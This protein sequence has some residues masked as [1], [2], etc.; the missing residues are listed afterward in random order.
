MSAAPQSAGNLTVRL[1]ER[2]LT[3][4]PSIG[5]ANRSLVTQ[6]VEHL[7]SQI[8]SGALA[9]DQKL[10]EQT[11]ADQLTV[12]RPPLREALRTLEADGFVRTVPRRGTYVTRLTMGDV[13]D[14]F[15]VREALE[16]AAARRAALRAASD[17][18]ITEALQGALTENQAAIR[19]GDPTRID[20][21][22]AEWHRQV[23]LLADNALLSNLMRAVRARQAWLLLK[24]NPHRSPEM[25]CQE[26]DAMTKAIV[27]GDADRAATL[28]W[29][30]VNA[31]RTPSATLLTGVLPD[32]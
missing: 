3:E 18:G 31:G 22:S 17:H 10:V 11:L 30:H 28:A 21:A 13:G 14:L 8:I 25:Q 15:D 2:L 24:A 9:P 16:S 4:A 27:A 26:H 20:A 5:S 29:E 19:S 12:S 32:A 6:I 23:V 1:G 7:R